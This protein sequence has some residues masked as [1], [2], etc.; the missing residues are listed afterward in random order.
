MFINVCHSPR[1]PLPARWLP[2]GE[3]PA[4]LNELGGLDSAHVPVK[5]QGTDDDCL[6]I[7]MVFSP[8]RPDVDHSGNSCAGESMLIII[9]WE[10]RL[11]GLGKSRD[12]LKVDK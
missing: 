10:S 1:I 3:L 4:K 11:I 6:C 12:F 7:P 8:P 5:Q 9:I 2:E